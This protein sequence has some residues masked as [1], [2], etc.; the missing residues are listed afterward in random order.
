MWTKQRKFKRWWS[1]IPLM[2][3]KRTITSHLKSLNTKRRT[4][5][6][7]VGNQGPGVGHVHNY[8]GLKSVVGIPT[9]PSPHQTHWFHYIQN[10]NLFGFPN[11]RFC[12]YLMKVIPE[13]R[14][15]KC[16]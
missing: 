6:Y 15:A 9:R 12:V 11:F 4:T 16:S 7:Y 1:T 13:T 5:E 14:R 8:S 2:S 3:T 10:F